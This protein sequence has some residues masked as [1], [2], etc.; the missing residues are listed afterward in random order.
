MNTYAQIVQ[1]YGDSDYCFI[2]FVLKS[3]AINPIKSRNIF[4]HEL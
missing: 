2:S 1:E 4:T 3:M